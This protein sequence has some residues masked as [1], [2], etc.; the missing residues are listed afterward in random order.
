ML[1]APASATRP[2]WSKALEQPAKEFSATALNVLAGKLPEGLRG[3]L[4]RNG[5]ARL[6]RGG[7]RVGHWFDGEGAILA[8][9]FTDAGATGLYRYVQTEACQKEAQADR[10]LFP[11]YGM[12][13]PGPFWNTWGKP[14]KNTANTSVLALVDRLLALWEGGNPHALDLVTLETRGRDQLSQLA[15]GDPFSAHPKVDPKT[16]EI[17]NFGVEAGRNATLRLYRSDPTGKIIQ[18]GAVELDGLP[19]I[20]D[21]AFAGRYLVFFVPPV[22]ASLLPLMLGLSSYSEALKWKPQLGTQV[23]AIDRETLSVVSRGETEP[24]YQWHFA[25]AYEDEADSVVVE[26]V[27]YCDFRT[28]Q[29]LKEVASGKT[30]TQAKA[31]LHQV[32]LNP[33]TGAIT[34]CEQLSDRGCEFPVVDQSSVGQLWRYTYLAVHRDGA[35]PK[36]ELFGAIAAFDHKTQELIVADAGENRYPSEPIPAPDRFNCHRV[37]VLTVVYDANSH[38]SELWIYERDRLNADPVCRLGLPHV[39]PHS[40]HGTWKST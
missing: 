19:L 15:V 30:K 34:A 33:Q 17:F 4:Y 14:V 25:N 9:H 40:F 39:I 35:D 5:P 36:R 11:N 8:I 7:K 18:Q 32:R 24:W 21:F 2:A 29:F 23:L 10:F 20:H 37:W 38:T 1:T 12:A 22:R 6:E 27:R 31:T 28:N 26:I 13:A 16:G 3:S